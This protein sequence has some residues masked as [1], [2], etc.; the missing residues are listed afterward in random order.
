MSPSIAAPSIGIKTHTKKWHQQMALI[1]LCEE[2]IDPTGSDVRCVR[3]TRICDVIIQ[4]DSSARCQ[5]IH[6]TKTE[7]EPQIRIF[8]NPSLGFRQSEPQTRKIDY[9]SKKVNFRDLKSRNRF[10]FFFRTHKTCWECVFCK[11]TA[12]HLVKFCLG[13][14]IYNLHPSIWASHSMLYFQPRYQRNI[15]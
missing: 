14:T 4:L 7:T 3:N 13:N 11:K 2:D 1:L 9:P 6:L 5:I 15:V 10:Q 8:N 12:S